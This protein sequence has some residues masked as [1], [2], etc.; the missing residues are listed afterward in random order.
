LIPV[1]RQSLP[2]V[3][4]AEVV[5]PRGIPACLWFLTRDKTGENLEHGG[6]GRKGEI[7]FIDAREFGTL[8]T[9]TLRVLTRRTTA[10]RSPRSTRGGWRIWRSALGRANV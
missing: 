1:S 9:R 4:C 2:V 6:R 5:R 3:D 10:S 7:L 8:Q